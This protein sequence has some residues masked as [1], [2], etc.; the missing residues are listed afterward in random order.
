M[1]IGIDGSRAFIKRRTG[2]EEYSYQVIKGLRD[3][4][5]DAQTVFLY[6]RK[7]QEVDFELPKNWRVKKINFWRGWQSSMP[8]DPFLYYATV[9][10]T[11]FYAILIN[12]RNI[13]SA[14]EIMSA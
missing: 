1:L 8:V 7:N 14:R 2:I 11:N 10:V 5:K 9:L 4:L 3:K 12:K 13:S 6:I